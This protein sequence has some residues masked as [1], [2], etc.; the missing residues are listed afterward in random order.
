MKKNENIL[1]VAIIAIVLIAVIVSKLSKKDR[2]ALTSPPPSSGILNSDSR[3]QT[4]QPSDTF[5][6]NL[7]AQ[8]SPQ[9]VIVS[10]KPEGKGFR[11]LADPFCQSE[12]RGFL[13]LPS[14]FLREFY[15]K[16][17]AVIALPQ[18]LANCFKT[19][20][21][22]QFVFFEYFRVY[23]LPWLPLV[24]MNGQIREIKHYSNF[25][26]LEKDLQS[27]KFNLKEL[28]QKRGLSDILTGF[29]IEDVNS[30]WVLIK[31]AQSNIESSPAYWPEVPPIHATAQIID[32]EQLEKVIS[33]VSKETLFVDVRSKSE[34]EKFKIQYRSVVFKAKESGMHRKIL[35][36]TDF[37]K[38]PNKEIMKLKRKTKLVIF[39]NNE[40]DLNVFNA[41]NFLTM[42]G[43][44]EIFILRKGVAELGG[45]SP[46]KELLT[47]PLIEAD[48]LRNLR[49]ENSNIMIVDCRNPGVSSETIPGAFQIS[50]QKNDKNESFDVSQLLKEIESKRPTRIVLYGSNGLDPKPNRV[51]KLLGPM[52]SRTSILRDGF[53][54]WQYASKYRWASSETKKLPRTGASPSPERRKVVTSLSPIV[55]IPSSSQGKQPVAV[56]PSTVTEEDLKK[57]KSDS[58]KK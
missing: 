50:F 3:S 18:S 41:A 21:T 26:A 51:K 14:L 47:Q 6:P 37:H 55:K 13:I 52:E 4:N 48:D 19:N 45:K 30:P 25:S 57:L 38:K 11:K 24:K 7:A 20:K 46:R 12:S 53:A 43:F 42:A 10:E 17:D 33:Q 32:K 8:T 58:R 1:L 27:I 34:Q 44:K 31:I 23:Q 39:G 2:A 40:F 35:E 56:P 9:N 15:F 36:P 28:H 49:K 5:D 54:G 22:A 16:R 29:F